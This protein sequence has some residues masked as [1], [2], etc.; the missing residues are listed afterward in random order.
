M[1][2]SHSQSSL[3]SMI[4]DDMLQASIDQADVIKSCT[5]DYPLPRV[6][7]QKVQRSLVYKTMHQCHHDHSLALLSPV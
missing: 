3:S 4:A 2:G 1:R 6:N 5:E 7:I